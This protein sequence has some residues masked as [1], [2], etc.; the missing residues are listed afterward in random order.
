MRPSGAL[1]VKEKHRNGIVRI[2]QNRGT[3][4]T[5]RIDF[6]ARGIWDQSSILDMS[7]KVDAREIAAKEAEIGRHE[8]VRHAINRRCVV[9]VAR[10]ARKNL[11]LVIAG[12]QR[13]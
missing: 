6:R 11:R 13:V 7:G 8:I 12:E 9:A 4:Q 3:A 5:G 10:S 1:D 2:E